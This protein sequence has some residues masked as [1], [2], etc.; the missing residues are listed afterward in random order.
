ML[1]KPALLGFDLPL[2]HVDVSWCE[3]T[4]ETKSLRFADQVGELRVLRLLKKEGGKESLI[5]CCN[6]GCKIRMSHVSDNK[7]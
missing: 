3:V 4:I 7:K 1:L 6:E 5:D 2:R